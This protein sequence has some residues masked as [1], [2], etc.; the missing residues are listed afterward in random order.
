MGEGPLR[1]SV[2][3][4]NRCTAI[5]IATCARF[6]NLKKAAGLPMLQPRCPYWV[7]MMIRLSMISKCVSGVHG[8]FA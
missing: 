1:F 3:V 5:G 7:E 8:L 2:C 6:P 4:V